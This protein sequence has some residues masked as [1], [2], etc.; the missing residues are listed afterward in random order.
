MALRLSPSL[1]AR[2]PTLHRMLQE[3]TAAG[4]MPASPPPLPGGTWAHPPTPASPS[5]CFT[6]LGPSFQHNTAPI[7]ARF[8]AQDPSPFWNISPYS[9]HFPVFP[10]AAKCKVFFFFFHFA[11]KLWLETCLRDLQSREAR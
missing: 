8:M 7:L 2:V 5:P 3:N 1:F 6:Q 11:V 9:A 10:R 4:R